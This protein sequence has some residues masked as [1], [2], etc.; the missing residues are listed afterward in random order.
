MP[1]QIFPSAAQSYAAMA[2][3]VAVAS[4]NSSTAVLAS[5]NH[6]QASLEQPAHSHVQQGHHHTHHHVRTLLQDLSWD[7][8][9]AASARLRS[10]LA[11]TPKGLHGHVHTAAHSLHGLAGQ[12]Q[13]WIGE[14]CIPAGPHT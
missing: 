7:A 3:S 10:F 13:S 2:A 4:A 9:R 12:V 5:S 8:D 14:P 1:G 6:T 11:V